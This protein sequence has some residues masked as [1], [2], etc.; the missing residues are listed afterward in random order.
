M[1]AR[2]GFILLLAFTSSAFAQF[3]PALV[4][5][6][7]YWSDG[8]SEL[9]LYAAD[10]TRDGQPHQCELVLIFTPESVDP[11]SFEQLSDVKP[12]ERLPAIEMNETATLSRG[13]TTEQRSIRAV[14]RINA[15]SL[16]R[17]SFAGTDG[18]GQIFK[19]VREVRNNEN[20]TWQYVCDTYRDLADLQEI[21]SPK[22]I[23]I[24][25]GELP[26]RVRTLDFSKTTGEGD[27]HLFPTLARPERQPNKFA[28]AKISWKINDRT[29]DVD[30]SHADGKDHF[31]LDRDFPFLLR[32]WQMADGSR[33][34]MKN[35]LKVD[36]KNYLKNGDRE[37][38]LKDPML[39]HPD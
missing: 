21:E 33:L 30:L 23:A 31:V 28:P 8:K 18:L 13:L 2:V 16:A 19:R 26:L 10:F 12:A 17:I 1:I 11:I 38:A 36:Y 34:R 7:S 32:E 4:Q 39:R 29:I 9:N 22:P 14:W 15:M 5:N 20:V 3:S 35:S 25:Y 6:A 37:R 24:F 27:L